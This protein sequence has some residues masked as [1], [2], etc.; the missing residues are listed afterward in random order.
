M[1]WRFFLGSLCYVFFP[2]ILVIHPW[3]FTLAKVI[4]RDMSCVPIFSQKKFLAF[5]R[6]QNDFCKSFACKNNIFVELLR[7]EKRKVFGQP[8]QSWSRKRKSYAHT[9][10][11]LPLVP[12]AAVLRSVVCSGFVYGIPAVVALIFYWITKP[13]KPFWMLLCRWYH[14]VT[15]WL[16]EKSN[17]CTYEYMPILRYRLTYRLPFVSMNLLCLH[18]HSNISDLYVTIYNWDF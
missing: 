18:S 17:T 6:P 13:W 9:I 7:C 15:Q 10:L 1:T 4:E 3:K 5:L 12:L 8:N 14:V 2:E 16:T 11:F